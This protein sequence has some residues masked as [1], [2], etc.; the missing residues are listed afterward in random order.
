MLSVVPPEVAV[1]GQ[2]LHLLMLPSD[3]PGSDRNRKYVSGQAGERQ[4]GTTQPGSSRRLTPPAFRATCV[5]TD[6]RGGAVLD[7]AALSA[8]EEELNCRRVRG[9]GRQ[10][11]KRGASQQRQSSG[12]PSG[13]Y[14]SSLPPTVINEAKRRRLVL[15]SQVVIPSLD[16]LGPM[17][18]RTRGA[19]VRE[20]VDAPSW[21]RGSPALLLPRLPNLGREPIGLQLLHHLQSGQ[22]RVGVD[23]LVS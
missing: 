6:A 10:Q 2:L 13:V 5:L 19:G 12:R 17:R 16:N 18:G 4:T 9:E 21:R 23:G 20:Q 11:L 22:A 7:A 8:W 15:Q 3:S 1:L 14:P